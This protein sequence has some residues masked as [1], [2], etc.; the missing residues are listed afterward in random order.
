MRR[1]YLGLFAWELPTGPVFPETPDQI[2][3]WPKGSPV[4]KRVTLSQL[5]SKSVSQK[6]PELNPSTESEPAILA[7]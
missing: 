6:K 7:R 3:G 1:S 5:I 4:E 2:L